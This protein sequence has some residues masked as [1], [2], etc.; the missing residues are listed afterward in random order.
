ML[1]RSKTKSMYIFIMR[2]IKRKKYLIKITLLRL[3]FTFLKAD[4]GRIGEAQFETQW[5]QRGQ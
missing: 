5:R 1:D 4:G 2:Y 3:L